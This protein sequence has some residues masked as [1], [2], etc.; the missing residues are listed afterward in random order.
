MAQA[1][2]F[3]HEADE[4]LPP[5][6]AT[7]RMVRC[8]M[9]AMSLAESQL[10]RLLSTLFGGDRVIPAMSVVSVC[11]GNRTSIRSQGEQFRHWL[12]SAKC[13]FTVVDADDNPR[14]VVEFSDGSQGEISVA[15]LNHQRHL[16]PLLSFYGVHYVVFSSQ[17]LG[18]LLDPDSTVDIVKMFEAKLDVE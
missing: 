8:G 1:L 7:P 9:I 14:M 18:E 11:G 17:E 12:E 5:W 15:Q 16:R 4:L 10:F 6:E 3:V 2:S 13:Q